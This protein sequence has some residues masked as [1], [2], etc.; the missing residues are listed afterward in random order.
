MVTRNLIIRLCKAS[1]PLALQAIGCRRTCFSNSGSTNRSRTPYLKTRVTWVGKIKQKITEILD[2]K[3]L[4]FF[5]NLSS[6]IVGPIMKRPFGFFED[7]FFP[8]WIVFWCLSWSWPRCFF[9]IES[10]KSFFAAAAAAALSGGLFEIKFGAKMIYEGFSF[11]LVD[12]C[13]HVRSLNKIGWKADILL[14]EKNPAPPIIYE[15]LQKWDILH[16][17]WCRISSISSIMTWSVIGCCFWY[18][19]VGPHKET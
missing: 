13:R 11:F 8:R 12:A 4:L 1:T 5:P 17:N 2:E 14:M 10:A 6:Q 3:L 18:S 19:M 9:L 15:T 7:G 16:I